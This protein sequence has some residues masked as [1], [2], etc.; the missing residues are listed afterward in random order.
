MAIDG[1]NVNIPSALP[2]DVAAQSLQA[3]MESQ[4]KIDESDAEA[5]KKKAAEKKLLQKQSE[6]KHSVVNRESFQR[7]TQTQQKLQQILGGAAGGDAANALAGWNNNNQLQGK[8]T[9]AQKNLFREAMANNPRQGTDAANALNRLT[10]QPGFQ[11]AITNSQ[12]M[13][14]LQ[15]GV[16]QNP[17]GGEKPAAQMLQ[18]RFMQSGKADAQTKNQFLRFGLQQAG[19]GNLDAMKRAGDLLGT[20]A[21]RGMPRSAQRAAM[22]MAA[23]TPGDAGATSNVDS[24]AQNADVHA[25]PNFARG[26]ATELLAKAGGKKEVKEGFEQLAANGKFKGQTAENKGRFFS[27]IGSGRPSEFRAI[28]DKLLGSLQTPGFPN[29]A[30]QVGKFLNK[31]SQQVQKGGASGI[32]TSQAM[33]E[34]KKSSLPP[35]PKLVST[36]DMDEEELAQARAQNRAQLMHFFNQVQRHYEQAEKK[37]GSAKYLE[38]VNALQTLREPPQVDTSALAPEELALYEER[39][40]AIKAKL[41]LV[42]KLQREKSR[43]L[44]NKRMPPAKRRAKMAARRVQGKQPKYFNPNAG[45][46][47]GGQI[48]T[49][50]AGGAQPAGLPST[51]ARGLRAARPAP[52]AAG[53]I[54]AQV[55][56][57]VSQLGNGP[58]TAER[59]GQVAQAIAQQVA[60]QVAQQVTQQLLGNA[61][62]V[63]I[64]DPN[65]AEMPQGE[66]D[67]IA[68]KERAQSGKVDGWGIQRTFDRDLGAAA[69]RTAVKPPSAQP[70]ME[71]GPSP[72]QVMNEV[73]TGRMLVKDPTSVRSLADA[74]NT[75]WRDLNRGEQALLKNMGWSQQSWDTKETQAAKW[76]MTMMTPFVNLNPVQREAVRKLGFSPADWD[77]R[78]GEFQRVT[79]GKSGKNA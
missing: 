76:P 24:F 12:Q 78:V 27:T 55:A 11:K 35:L 23:R 2:P 75:N 48:F 43:E 69:Q 64:A 34:A 10:Q 61:P 1:I 38:D 5:A 79:A 8:L 18:S 41:G 14:T 20:L 22:N 28:S 73:Y 62:A 77:S 4:E 21:G 60:A 54:S 50:A 29:R 25:M 68:K 46:T 65:V 72:E 51:P 67:L 39:S 33:R 19:K 30:G 9:E 3:K 36:E 31:V 52:A 40:A 16:L 74:W 45:H 71:V 47:S 58:V 56:Q 44:R 13:G 7:R 57:A 53:D 15:Q 37:L 6:V 17:K 26:K 49:R 63:G 70:D 59:A 66:K 42:K 32:N